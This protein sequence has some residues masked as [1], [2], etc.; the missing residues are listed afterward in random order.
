L[1]IGIKAEHAVTA[2]REGARE[3]EADVAEADDPYSGGFRLDER[4][5]RVIRVDDCGVGRGTRP[6]FAEQCWHRILG[7]EE[8]S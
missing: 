2:G 7:L 5:K 1:G 6:A 8:I 3:R 4:P